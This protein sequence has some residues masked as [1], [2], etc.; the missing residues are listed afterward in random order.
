MGSLIKGFYT[1]IILIVLGEG[2]NHHFRLKLILSKYNHN[3]FFVFNIVEMLF[4]FLLTLKAP[5]KDLVIN[6]LLQTSDFLLI[7]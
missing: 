7:V 3:I 6:S 2:S 5:R 4:F 1:K